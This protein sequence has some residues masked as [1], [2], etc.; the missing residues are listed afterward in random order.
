VN[1]KNKLCLLLSAF[2]L[3]FDVHA[4]TENYLPVAG[5]IVQQDFPTKW[6]DLKKTTD[7][8]WHEYQ[9]KKN[10]TSLIF[11]SYGMLKLADHF[12][13]INDLVN[14]AE[15]AKLGFFYL[16]EAVDLHEKDMRV[17]YLRVR[18]DAWLPGN[19]GRCVI[20]LN[21]TEQLLKSAVKY[22]ESIRNNINA[23]RYRALKN[24]KQDELA[25][26]VLEQIK[27][28]MP[29]VDSLILDNNV[30]PAWDVSELEQIILPLMR[31]AHD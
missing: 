18:V 28:D 6:I 3:I 12:N 30:T 24:C 5:K 9:D 11:Y 29:E 21:D 14:S 25:G 15:Y 10:I 7:S 26:K 16:D 13:A 31:G 23:M 2:F 8:L 17:R 22:S 20:A 19:L 1:L 27:R 4:A